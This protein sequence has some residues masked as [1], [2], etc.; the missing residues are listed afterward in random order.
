MSRPFRFGVSFHAAPSAN[1]WRNTARKAEDLG[2]ST[3]LVSDHLRQGFQPMVALAVASEATTSIRL[4]TFVLNNDFRHPVMT[5]RESATLD[6]LSGGRFELGIGA[7]H[8]GDEYR[9]AGLTFDPAERRV[10]R[11]GEAVR[12]IRKL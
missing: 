9:E 1:D 8:S 11:L 3:F 12:L 5:A 10:E 6:L 7:G 2:F 4:G